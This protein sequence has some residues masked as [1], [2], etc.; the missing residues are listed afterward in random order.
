MRS[1][2]H[3]QHICAVVSSNKLWRYSIRV[4]LGEYIH[5]HLHWVY[6]IKCCLQLHSS[7]WQ[8]NLMRGMHYCHGC[9]MHQ[10]FCTLTVLHRWQS[11]V[12]GNLYFGPRGTVIVSCREILAGFALRN[13]R[14][15]IIT[16]FYKHMHTHT[17]THVCVYTQTQTHTCPWLHNL[18][19]QR[20]IFTGH[21]SKMERQKPVTKTVP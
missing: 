2:V 11:S 9:F 7:A 8:D 21:M 13:I 15:T 4:T 12:S 6:S 1:C 5:G 16:S 19:Y 10:L 18:M 3:W 17:S 20:L 14:A